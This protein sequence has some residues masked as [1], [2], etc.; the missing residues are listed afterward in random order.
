[1]ILLSKY[2]GIMSFIYALAT[3]YIIISLLNIYKI[4][5]QVNIKSGVIKDTMWITLAIIATILLGSNL[6]NLLNKLLSP[7]INI[8]IISIIMIFSFFAILLATS[9][10]KIA[11][12]KRIKLKKKNV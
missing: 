10:I 1:M 8:C 5:K 4:S 2:L 7:F 3:N 9:T 6:R 12:V 11:D